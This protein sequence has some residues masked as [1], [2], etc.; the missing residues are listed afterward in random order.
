MKTPN[1]LP[2]KM[3]AL[4]SLACALLATG[5]L[6]APERAGERTA[7]L[8]VE[9]VPDPVAPNRDVVLKMIAVRLSS[10]EGDTLRDTITEGGSLIS[11]FPVRLNPGDG[12]R[13]VHPVYALDPEKRW[14]VAVTTRDAR[15]SLVHRDSAAAGA[16]VD[17]SLRNMTLRLAP[18]F[19]AYEAHF[20]LPEAAVRRGYR[21]TRVKADVNGSKA[22]AT[23]A[24]GQSARLVCDY[25]PVGS[26][27]L[28]LRAYGAVHGEEGAAVLL[29][30]GAVGLQLSPEGGRVESVILESDHPE[31]AGA[32]GMKVRLGAVGKVRMDVVISGAL[33]L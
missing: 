33:D 17:G 23:E 9:I 20:A 31:L 3:L 2:R 6:T 29:Y 15:D 11:R 7:L 8:G 13:I 14:T 4:A 5:C 1:L 27:A 16:L 21:L 30:K 19:A 28:T 12:S 25:L 22:C 26:S 10:G 24:E 18:R 32:D